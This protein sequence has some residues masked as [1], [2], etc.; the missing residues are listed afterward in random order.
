MNETHSPVHDDE[1][2]AFVDGELPPDRREA[3]TA[4]LAEH[5][6]QAAMVA[7]WQAQAE[8]FRARYNAVVELAET[9]KETENF[10]VNRELRSIELTTADMAFVNGD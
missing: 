4:W 1:L 8:A 6:E 3:V 7:A 9:V 5:P 2:H 10:L